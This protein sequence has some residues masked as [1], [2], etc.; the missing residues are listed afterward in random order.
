MCD[1]HHGWQPL[2]FITCANMIIIKIKNNNIK[3]KSWLATT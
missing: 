2:E 1:E 3:K